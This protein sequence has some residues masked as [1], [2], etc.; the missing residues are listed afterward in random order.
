M[1]NHFPVS[2]F[3][4]RAHRQIPHSVKFIRN[5]AF[6]VAARPG[7]DLHAILSEAIASDK[8]KCLNMAAAKINSENAMRGLGRINDEETWKERRVSIYTN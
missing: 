1:I 8:L 3:R 5:L 2:P 6:L 7:V 4:A